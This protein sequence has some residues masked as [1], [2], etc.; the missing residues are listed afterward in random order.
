MLNNMMVNCKH[1][2]AVAFTLVKLPTN[3]VKTYNYGYAAQLIL[4][5]SASTLGRESVSYSKDATTS[6][7]YS[8]KNLKMIC[9]ITMASFLFNPRNPPNNPKHR[10][11]H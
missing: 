11:C 4:E 2:K 9:P 1:L 3:K 7:L 5:R 6:S 8:L 10:P